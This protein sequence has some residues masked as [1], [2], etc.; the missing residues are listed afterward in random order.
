M[1]VIFTF[2]TVNFCD[3]W[4]IIVAGPIFLVIQVYGVVQDS[5]MF[6]ACT[7]KHNIVLPSVIITVLAKLLPIVSI[8]IF[9]TDCLQIIQA[10]LLNVETLYKLCCAG[11]LSLFFVFVFLSLTHFQ[12]MY[13]FFFLSLSPPMFVI[14][15][16]NLLSHSLRWTGNTTS[17]CV[18]FRT[19][20]RW[21]TYI[22]F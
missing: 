8:I 2:H 7:V 14:I 22:P 1:R 10:E 18:L 21:P 5:W 3:T 11:L 6:S 13:L 20:M 16:D 17:Y 4:L 19:L 15:E 12:F 9:R